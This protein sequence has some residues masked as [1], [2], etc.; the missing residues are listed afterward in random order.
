[1]KPVKVLI[2]K[3]KRCLEWLARMGVN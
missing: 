3:E 2:N 1:M